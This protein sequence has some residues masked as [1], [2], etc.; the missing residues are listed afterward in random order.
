M[1]NHEI[2]CDVNT[3][4]VFALYEMWL[5]MPNRIGEA[6]IDRITQQWNNHQHCTNPTH[7]QSH[8]A[9]GNSFYAYRHGLLHV[10]VLNPYTFCDRGSVQYK[11]LR[12]ELKHNVNRTVTPWVLAVVHNPLHTTFNGHERLE[13]Y[14]DMEHLFNKYNVNLVVAGHDHG[15]MRS[16]SLTEQETLDESGMAPVYLIVGTGGSSEGPVHGY[17]NPDQQTAEPWVAARSFMAT[18]FGKLTLYNATHAE[19]EYRANNEMED[20]YY[21][22]VQD[23]VES[24]G[25]SADAAG[26]FMDRAWLLNAHA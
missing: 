14:D 21:R 26:S 22:H 18:G 15:Y 23:L 3:L 17:K 4:E 24:G 8:Y 2:E 1:G 11:W 16:Y 10:V 12:H 9:Y 6:Q 13:N 5:Y 19:W 7:F 20:W 25:E